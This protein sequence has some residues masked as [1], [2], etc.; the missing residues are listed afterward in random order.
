MTPDVQDLSLALC[1]LCHTPSPLS[2][3]AIT[4]GQSWRCA[5]C[6]QMWSAQRLKTVAAYG[7]WVAARSER[8]AVVKAA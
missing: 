3:Q 8:E 6:D 4:A 1:P 7:A 2:E 5:V